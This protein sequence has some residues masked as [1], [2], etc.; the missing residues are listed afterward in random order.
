MSL[1]LK[2]HCPV[3]RRPQVVD[4][5]DPS[6]LGPEP[7]FSRWHSFAPC[8]GGHPVGV[9]FDLRKPTNSRALRV[10]DGNIQDMV[11][12]DTVRVRQVG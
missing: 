7:P 4:L 8:P 10:T 12:E 1:L 3:C 11:A 2:V 6:P 9:F 5:H